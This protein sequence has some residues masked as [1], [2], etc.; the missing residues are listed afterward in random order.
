MYHSH[1]VGRGYFLTSLLYYKVDDSSEGEIHAGTQ[2]SMSS[3][4]EINIKTPFV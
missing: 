1:S 2:Q 4:V 3:P